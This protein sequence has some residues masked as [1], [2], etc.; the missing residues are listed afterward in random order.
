M[1]FSLSDE[2]RLL[3]D[4]V[5][6]FVRNNYDLES[7]RG[8][9]ATP[10]GFSEANWQMLAEVGWL[11]LPLPEDAGGLGGSAADLALMMVEFGRGCVLEPFVSTAVLGGAIVNRSM[12]RE[13]M[14]P[15]IAAGTLRLALA[16]D[17]THER[18][19]LRSR[20]TTSARSS[21]QGYLLT[22][23]KRLAL[24]APSAHKLLVTAMIEGDDAYS[25]FLV[26]RSASGLKLDSYPLIDGERAADISLHD[27]PA[28]LIVDAA[29]GVDVLDEAVD[30]ACVAWVAEAVGSM[31]ASIDACSD[32][33]KTRQQFGQP[34]GKFQALQH[35]LA[36]MFVNAQSAR[37]ILYHALA[38]VGG[39]AS[40]RNH[41]V[42]AAKIVAGDA[43]Q[44]VLRSAIQL[45]GGYGITDEYAV[46]HHYRRQLVLCTLFGDV[47]HHL[48][49][50]AGRYG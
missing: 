25:I 12:A 27:T 15:E 22:G 3:V 34:I 20:R 10:E 6:R 17:E 1:E 4:S 16:H 41:A 29:H 50:F 26:E 39:Q 11:A 23:E 49:R 18:F 32:Y 24:A 45:H 8:L 46:S 9:V 48:T 2:Q 43:G 7:R 19:N 38:N 44:A 21:G 35:M 30:R 5:S 33:L 37:S 13:E 40:V 42:S 14:I 28:T 36:E 47:D 31:E